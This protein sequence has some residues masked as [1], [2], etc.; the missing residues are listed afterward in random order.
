MVIVPRLAIVEIIYDARGRIAQLGHI[1]IEH[2]PSGLY[3]LRLT[4]AH[5]AASAVRTATFQLM[6]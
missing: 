2:L 6:E 5:G 1:S 4:V 3:T